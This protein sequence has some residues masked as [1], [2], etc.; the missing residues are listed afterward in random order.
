MYILHFIHSSIDGYLCYF[1]LLATVNNVPM[2]TGGKYLETLLS[3]L[4]DIVPR[5]ELY[6]Y[7]FLLYTIGTME[8]YP[9]FKRN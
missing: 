5:S 6:Q 7:T 9:V 4:L 8:Y 2:N 1:Q 3:L